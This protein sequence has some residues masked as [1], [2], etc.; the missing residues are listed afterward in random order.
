[1]D[2]GRVNY[3]L[4]K[5]I[6]GFQ[7][8]ELDALWEAAFKVPTPQ[9]MHKKYGM[10][11]GITA[12]EAMKP[13]ENALDSLNPYS[14]GKL[15]DPNRTPNRGKIRGALDALV[16]D[17]SKMSPG[18][19]KDVLSNIRHWLKIARAHAKRIE[20]ARHKKNEIDYQ[21]TL[22]ARAIRDMIDQARAIIAKQRGGGFMK[23][24]RVAEPKPKPK[25]KKATT[26]EFP[27]SVPKKWTK[28]LVNVYTTKGVEQR[29]GVIK[30]VWGIHR[31]IT[32][33]GWTIT[34]N[35]SG[36]AAKHL[37][38]QSVAKA[39]VDALIREEPELF[40][41]KDKNKIA[42]YGSLFRR[43]AGEL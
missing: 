13:V 25:P 9:Q 36:M 5:A 8:T 2:I 26:T 23:P 24:A 29:S 32:G 39:F 10:A 4:E 28:G 18:E 35:P 33:K 20:L 15:T 41:M 17:T 14:P 21:D 42:K 19:R 3:V 1:M 43:L 37:K 38:K 27:V 22:D 40:D 11:L 12:D 34:H 30:G 16:R 31:K 6:L 7:R